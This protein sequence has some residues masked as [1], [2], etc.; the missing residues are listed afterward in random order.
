VLKCSNPLPREWYS[1]TAEE[2]RNVACAT[3]GGIRDGAS[4]YLAGHDAGDRILT[5]TSMGDAAGQRIEPGKECGGIVRANLPLTI[6][7]Q[8]CQDGVWGWVV[9]KLRQYLPASITSYKSF[10]YLP[11]LLTFPFSL[12]FPPNPWLPSIQSW[13]ARPS[14]PSPQTRLFNMAQLG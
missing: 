14:S 12:L 6:S 2:G 9:F 8:A 1:T 3:N 5:M 11:S 10:L 13:R 7:V 4:T